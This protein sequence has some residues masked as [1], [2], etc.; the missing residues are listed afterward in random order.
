MAVRA[1]DDNLAREA[2]ARKTEHGESAAT[3]EKQWTLQKQAVDSGFWPLY[4]FNPV[5]EEGKNPFKL[6]SKMDIEG[7]EDFMYRQGRFNIL[8]KADPERAQYLDDLIH[9]D[10]ID[11]FEQY[12]KLAE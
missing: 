11:R 4:R 12:Q 2:L 1:G 5:T 3:L 9:Q 6:D 8:R 10:V 7:L